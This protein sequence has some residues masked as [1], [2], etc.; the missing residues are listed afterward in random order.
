MQIE[1]HVVL[2]IDACLHWVRPLREHSAPS[3]RLAVEHDMSK[4]GYGRGW[5]KAPGSS[6]VAAGAQGPSVLG[7]LFGGLR[8]YAGNV[9]A[10]AALDLVATRG[11]TFII[12]LRTDRHAP[13]PPRG[14]CERRK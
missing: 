2:E 8:G 10:P 11:N 12:D 9:S 6:K 7:A 3:R 14:A 13:P 4:A 5:N 1:R